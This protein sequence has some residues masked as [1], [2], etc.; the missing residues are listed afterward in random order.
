MVPEMPISCNG[1]FEVRGGIRDVGNIPQIFH[2][3]HLSRPK[4]PTRRRS[5]PGAAPERRW[6]LPA[7]GPKQAR[8]LGEESVCQKSPRWL[9]DGIP[10]ASKHL[11][12][13]IILESSYG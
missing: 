12:F 10:A 4:L 7:K 13:C 3:S 2:V 6:Q 5:S 9:N 11:V 1:M 8:A